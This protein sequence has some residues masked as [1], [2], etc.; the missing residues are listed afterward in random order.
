MVVDGREALELFEGCELLAGP[1]SLLE[2]KRMD[3][4]GKAALDNGK[5]C[6]HLRQ[7]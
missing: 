7:H 4:D 5:Y 6:Q 3:S 2:T 1:V